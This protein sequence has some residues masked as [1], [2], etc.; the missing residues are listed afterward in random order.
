[1][2][3]EL[4]VDSSPGVVDL[5]PALPDAWP[6]G[7]VYGAVC[8]GRVTVEEL[9][10]DPHG[11]R[12]QLRSPVT[13]RVVVRSPYWQQKVRLPANKPVSVSFSTASPTES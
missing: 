1:M 7:T 11:V 10:S 9:S 4:L 8:R 5:L 12:A 3:L 2:L 6:N 13:Q